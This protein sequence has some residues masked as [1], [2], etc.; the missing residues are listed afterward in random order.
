M[1]VNMKK[2]EIL[3]LLFF[4]MGSFFSLLGDEIIIYE[5]K[6]FDLH[7]REKN[8]EINFDESNNT[9]LLYHED[10]FATFCFVFNK[11]TKEE[12]IK[13]LDKVIE[14]HNIAEKN[15]IE[16]VKKEINQLQLDGYLKFGSNWHK[17]DKII[18]KFYF[19]SI[20]SGNLRNTVL[21]ILSTKF[22]S[23]KNEFVSE[24]HNGLA[25]SKD[26]VIKIK[27]A[28]T[29]ENIQKVIEQNKKKNENIDKLFK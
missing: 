19:I 17:T 2:L 16:N 13:A 5:G 29:D 22:N 11:E 20:K 23:I 6:G 18:A 3:M 8:F 7:T 4:V 14:W 28:I 24:T 1:E 21:L 15:N 25:I 26:D 27:Q 9:I 12:F 10:I